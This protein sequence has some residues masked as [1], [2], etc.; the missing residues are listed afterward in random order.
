MR[1]IK[2]TLF[3]VMMTLLVSC[4]NVTNKL[5]F[6]HELKESISEKYDIEEVELKMNNGSNL[7]VII[8]DSK[9]KNYDSKKKQRISRAIGKISTN[10]RDDGETIK[11]GTVRFVSEENYGIVE[12]SDSEDFNMFK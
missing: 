7:I 9:F 6:M 3:T 12:T 11:S 8:K 4:S 1:K 2:F 5:S 10:L